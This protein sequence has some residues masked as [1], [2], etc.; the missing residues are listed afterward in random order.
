MSRKNLILMAVAV[1]ALVAVSLVQKSSHNRRVSASDTRPVLAVQFKQDDINRVR[2]AY[3][4]D[5]TGVVLE[6]LPDKWVVRSAWSHPADKKKITDLLKELQDL[7]GEFRS[8][9][10]AVLP[11][12]GFSDSTATRLTLFGK[13]WQPLFTLQIGN[14]PKRGGGAFVRLQGQPTV[15]LTRANL[16]GR[17]GM[18]GAND[19]PQARYF[20]DLQVWKK[21]RQDVDAITL[22]QDGKTMRLEKVFPKTV[23]PDSTAPDSVKAAPPRPDRSTW[24]WVLVRKGKRLPLAKTKCDAVLDAAVNVRANDIADPDSSLE[25]YGL[26]KVTRRV[27]ISLRDGSELEMRFGK[28]RPNGKGRPGGTYMMTSQDRTVWLLPDYKVN[29][30]FK[31]EKDLLPES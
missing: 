5:T 14:R 19:R 15:Y 9:K 4:A 29:Q 1:V 12:Y 8:D 23:K 3:G 28:Q 18:Y 30:L 11:D 17:L 25:T 2:L 10:A 16:L 31:K 13:E 24:E 20:L 21:D 7:R 22:V 6:K 26:W 27:K